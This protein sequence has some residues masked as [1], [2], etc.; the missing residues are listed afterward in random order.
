MVLTYI[1]I[2]TL[3]SQ[4]TLLGLKLYREISEEI[5]LEKGKNKK[6]PV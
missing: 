6:S 4:T 1:Y 5:H 2:A 3:I